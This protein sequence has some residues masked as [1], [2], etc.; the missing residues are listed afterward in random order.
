MSDILSLIL[1]ET[2][3]IPKVVFSWALFDFECVLV[4]MFHTENLFVF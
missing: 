3:R 2:H 4:N 1:C